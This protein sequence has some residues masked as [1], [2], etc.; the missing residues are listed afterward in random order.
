MVQRGERR[1]DHTR[2]IR[3]NPVVR[4]TGRNPFFLDSLRPRMTL[5][6]APS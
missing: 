2:L 1:R 4:A 5:A 6:S 3:Y